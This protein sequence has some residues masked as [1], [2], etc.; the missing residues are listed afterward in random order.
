MTRSKPA[1]DDFTTEDGLL[2]LSGWASDGLTD[3]QIAEEKIGISERSF[4]RWKKADASIVSA[5][6]KGREPVERRVENALVKSALGERVTLRK[7]IKVRIE[8]QK[9]GEG[10]IVEEHI[11]Y[12]EEEVYIPPN[13]TAIIYYLK[14]RRP[15]KWRDKPEQKD[16]T[17]LDMLDKI[18][19][20]IGGVE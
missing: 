10:K 11:E 6:K 17:A 15:D 12:A 19:E 5:L 16:S 4:S 2:R 7:P 20:Q 8:K 13:I 18:M 3:K 1:I 9:A 14:N